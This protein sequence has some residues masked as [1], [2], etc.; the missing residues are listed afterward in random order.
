MFLTTLTNYLTIA[1]N[2]FHV[3]VLS[4][5]LNNKFLEGTHRFLL[6]LCDSLH[7]NTVLGKQ[8]ELNRY[9]LKEVE[10]FLQDRAERAL[11]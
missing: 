9:V 2:F 11:D 7:P 8:K 3:H 1:L 4:S 10:N 6:L 5:Q